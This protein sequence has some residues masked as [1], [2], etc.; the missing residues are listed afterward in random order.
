MN[1]IATGIVGLLAILIFCVGGAAASDLT[2]GKTTMGKGGTKV[3]IGLNKCPSPIGT[4]VLLEEMPM[5]QYYALSIPGYRAPVNP[6]PLVALMMRASNCFI[7]LARGATSE[8]IQR[9]RALAESG[10]LQ[11]GSNMGA[12]Q[13]VAADYILQPQIVY[14]DQNAGGGALG[15]GVF[16]KRSLLG[17]LFKKKKVSAQ[18]MLTLTNVRTSVQE[19]AVEGSAT[20]SDIALGG[21]GWMKSAGVGGGVYESTDIE[22]VIAIA[23]TDAHNKLVAQLLASGM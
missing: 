15:G 11:K 19:A 22:K 18:V 13:M 2:S 4:A 23:F 9:E 3:T 6:A 10:Q 1:K 17:G 14:E 20:K 5:Q 12:G 8:L 16:R 21:F 7:V